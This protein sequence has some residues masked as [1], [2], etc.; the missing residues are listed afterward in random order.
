M[1]PVIKSENARIAS[2]VLIDI[3]GSDLGEYINR[4]KQALQQQLKLPSDYSITWTGQYQYMQRAKA[5][6]QILIPLTL[7]IIILLLYL[8]FKRASE[9]LIILGTLPFA[10][11]G[12]VWLLYFLNYNLSVAVAVG[13]I[14]LAGVAVEIGVVMLVYLNE[15][16]E[17]QKLLAEE[18]NCIIMTQDIKQ[19]I[20]NG[21]L[22]RLR[23]ILMTVSAIIGGFL[24]IMLLKGTGIEVTRRIAAPMIGGM[25]S[26]TALTLLVIPAAFLLWK[27]ITYTMGNLNQK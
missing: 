9:V 18:E 8:Y 4:A 27:K 24:P 5:R 21:T 7:G 3:K 1:A 14:A 13:F 10:L 25:L 20:I 12:G 26:A 19:A 6:L 15:A 2:W 22:L 11:V 16:F 17:K 23:P